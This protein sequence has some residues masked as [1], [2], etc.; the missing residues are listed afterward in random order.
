MHAVGVRPVVFEYDLDGVPNFGAQYRPQN[1]QMLPLRGARLQGRERS[2]GVLA[3]HRLTVY[4]ADAM[5]TAFGIDLLHGRKRLAADLV[6]AAGC[7]VPFQLIGGHIVSVRLGRLRAS[8]RSRDSDG[9][10]HGY[11]GKNDVANHV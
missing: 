7:V 6:D 2:I 11:D 5:R 1:S 9:Q 3:I 8:R 10:R 4:E